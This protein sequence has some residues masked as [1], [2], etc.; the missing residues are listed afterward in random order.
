MQRSYLK[1]ISE[2]LGRTMELLHY[3]HAGQPAIV[4]P[5]SAGRFHDWEDR[6]M[7]EALR[8]PLTAG[9]LQLVCVDSVDSESWYNQQISPRQRVLRQQRYEEYVLHEAM[10]RID[11]AHG[12]AWLATG[13]SLGGYH[14][15][16]LVLR[17]PQRFSAMIAMAGAFDLSGFLDG[18][19]DLDCYYQLPTYYLPRLTD[20]WFLDRYRQIHMVLATGE[21]DPCLAQNQQM[22]TIFHEKHLPHTLD[23][24]QTTGAHDW[25]TW[26]QMVV[27][28]LSGR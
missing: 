18:F 23:I 10:P 3:G 5:T 19:C 27:Q 16:N 24:W 25:P 11:S 8:A 21:D 26:Q 15:L 6:G 28:Y 4:F 22:S 20:S 7:V 13:C 1:H 9:Q 12:W 17:H 14:A 2:R